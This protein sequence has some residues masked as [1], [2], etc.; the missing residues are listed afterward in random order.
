MQIVPSE[1][2]KYCK[3][4]GWEI[5]IGFD[6]ED[7]ESSLRFVMGRYEQNGNTAVYLSGKE[8]KDLLTLNNIIGT[9]SLV[10]NILE[11]KQMDMDK[12]IHDLIYNTLSKYVLQMLN[13]T[14]GE[15]LFSEIIPLPH[16]KDTYFRNDHD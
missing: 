11:S 2:E 6:I 12:K 16:H 9:N 5:Y 8:M 15:V 1:I 10:A 14:L 13:A 3:K 7:K 4:N